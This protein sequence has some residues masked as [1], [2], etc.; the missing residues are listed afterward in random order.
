MV[1]HGM[2]FEHFSNLIRLPTGNQ[3]AGSKK[4]VIKMVSID[5]KDCVTYNVT[6]T[7]KKKPRKLKMSSKI[8]FLEPSS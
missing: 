8:I 7:A 6:K 2:A 5:I 1:F 4:T 3:A